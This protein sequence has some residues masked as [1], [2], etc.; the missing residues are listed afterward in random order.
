M[1]ATIALDDGLILPH[2]ANPTGS[3]FRERQELVQIRG[4]ALRGRHICR[5]KA[6][7]WCL[8]RRTRTPALSWSMQRDPTPRTGS[9]A[10][11][12]ASTSS[13]TGSAACRRSSCRY[14]GPQGYRTCRPLLVTE[15]VRCVGAAA[16]PSWSRNTRAG[17]ERAELIHVHYEPLPRGD[18]PRVG[19]PG[20]CAVDAHQ[21]GDVIGPGRPT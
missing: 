1:I 3:N 14:G 19:Y 17:A 4:R 18:R 16:F 15:H 11:S 21:R 6:S 9:S 12:P 8:C 2:S 10:C 13:P 5:T 20:R 7:A